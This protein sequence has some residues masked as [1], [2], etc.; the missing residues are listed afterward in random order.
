MWYE[1]K[2]DRFLVFPSELGWMS[3]RMRYGVICQLAFGH[4]SAAMAINAITQDPVARRKLKHG[5]KTAFSRCPALQIGEILSHIPDAAARKA[6]DQLLRY[7]AGEP[8]DF[9]ELE[10]D[11]SPATRFQA[12]VLNA[13]RTIPYG[14]TV[15]YGELAARVGVPGASRAVGSVMSGNR[16]PLIVPCHRVVRS[17]AKNRIASVPDEPTALER[18]IGHFSAPG[19]SAMKYRLLKMESLA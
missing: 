8:V 12:D 6:V 2:D 17:A 13:C 3:L 4:S 5:C 7:A 9:C 1:A 18:T 15:S 11:P 16:V 19:G 14:Q 10:V